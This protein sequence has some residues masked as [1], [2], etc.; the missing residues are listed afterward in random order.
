MLEGEHWEK[1]Q[2]LV[3]QLMK[4]SSRHWYWSTLWRSR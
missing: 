1:K 2:C 4:W 3:R